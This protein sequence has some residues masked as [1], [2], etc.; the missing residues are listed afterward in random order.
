MIK[1]IWLIPY[2]IF[3]SLAVSD[4]ML[5]YLNHFAQ[6]RGLAP[7]KYFWGIDRYFINYKS[8]NISYWFVKIAS[9]MIMVSI[10]L[11]YGF[12]LSSFKFIILFHLLIIIGITDVHYKIIPNEINLLGIIAGL[13]IVFLN[14]GSGNLITKVYILIFTLL[15]LLLFSFMSLGGIGGGDI[16]LIALLGVYVGW[17][18]NIIILTISILLAFLVN[19]YM[20][21]TKK[22]KFGDKFEFGPYLVIGT[23]LNYILYIM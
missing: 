15:F 18:N 8:R 21:I 12:S 22:R 6:K 20:L 2:L 1:D 17:Q 10:Y 4:L 11:Q 3:I 19:T 16:K 13:I 14:G 5:I 7:K 9:L 23:M